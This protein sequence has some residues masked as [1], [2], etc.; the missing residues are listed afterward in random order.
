M[1]LQQRRHLMVMELN[2]RLVSNECAFCSLPP[3]PSLQ[4]RCHII[5]P[6]S[7]SDIHLFPTNFGQS[8]WN[9]VK[10]QPI[11]TVRPLNHA[12]T[13]AEMPN[14]R[15]CL[16]FFPNCIHCRLNWPEKGV[17]TPSSHS[18]SGVVQHNANNA[19][20]VRRT[21]SPICQVSRWWHSAFLGHCPL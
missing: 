4:P 16:H 13:A 3:P 5:P 20:I 15:N 8:V 18:E 12:R 1:L 6:V 19:A 9:S 11:S 2:Y 7:L 10:K 17:V 21:M 14:R